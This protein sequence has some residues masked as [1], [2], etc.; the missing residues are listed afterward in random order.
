MCSIFGFP[1]ISNNPLYQIIHLINQVFCDQYDKANPES[2]VEHDIHLNPN[3]VALCYDRSRSHHGIQCFP[4]T[5]V[6]SLCICSVHAGVCLLR[7]NGLGVLKMRVLYSMGLFFCDK[8]R[9]LI[10]HV[11]LSSILISLLLS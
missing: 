7:T 3:I 9:D 2:T 4:Q 8:N 5:T 10:R 6:P 11:S 1:S